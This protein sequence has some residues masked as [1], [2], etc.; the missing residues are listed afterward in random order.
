MQEGL[1]SH[2][3]FGF[4]AWCF[5]E[6]HFDLGWVGLV[7][8]S[9]IILAGKGGWGWKQQYFPWGGSSL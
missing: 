6:V 7:A 2:L 1:S 5:F 3:L 4:I 9:E 8:V